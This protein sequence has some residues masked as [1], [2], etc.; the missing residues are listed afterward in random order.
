[1]KCTTPSASNNNCQD[2]FRA[3]YG[4]DGTPISEISDGDILYAPQQIKFNTNHREQERIGI[5]S[6][7]QWQPTDALE[8]YLDFNYNEFDIST[9]SNTVQANNECPAIKLYL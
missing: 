3:V 1:M 8:L 9:S 6:G 5:T 2:H 7:L 4:S